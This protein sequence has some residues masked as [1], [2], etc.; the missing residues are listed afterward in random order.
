MTRGFWEGSQSLQSCAR[1]P[2]NSSILPARGPL[3]AA[4]AG[5]VG[6]WPRM[7]PPS[8]GPPRCQQSKRRARQLS[9]E[10]AGIVVRAS[11]E[12]GAAADGLCGAGGALGVV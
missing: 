1:S 10:P 5:G 2:H 9:R 11:L 7:P 8:F 3:G 4:Q 12:R 6:E